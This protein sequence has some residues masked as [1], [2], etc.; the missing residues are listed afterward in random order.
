MSRAGGGKLLVARD[1]VGF[2]VGDGELRL[3]VEHFFKMRDVPACIGRVAV[4]AP[5]KMIVDAPGG[6]V[7]QRGEVHFQRVPAL[8]RIRAVAGVDA[9]EQVE[10]DGLRK[11]RRVAET[12]VLGVEASGE[13]LATGVEQCEAGHGLAG[14]ARG[15]R[16][17]LAQLGDDLV[18][19]LLDFGAMLAPGV[20]DLGQD[21]CQAGLAAAVGGGK[22]GAAGERLEF[23]RQKD[24][25]G[26]AAAAG[27]R[28]DE[29]HVGGVH[30]GTFL[31]VH[32]DR[33]E[34]VVHELGDGRILE[35]FPL[36]HVAPVAGRVADGKEDGLVF[37]ARLGEGFLAPRIPIDG[38][39]RVLEQVGRFL[40]NEAVGVLR[41][42]AD[43]GLGVEGRKGKQNDTDEESR[44]GMEEGKSEHGGKSKPR[45][46]TRRA[47][48]QAG[49]DRA[50][51]G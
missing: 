41:G 49:M 27:R 23:R 20:G 43:G 50:A 25:H 14:L 28:L 48:R 37:L 11:L 12:A 8:G 31:A 7:T 40:V 42:R 47:R 16:R 38:I 32:L 44:R 9:G 22:V 34:G 51:A 13:L 17:E 5:A 21:G 46:V 24:R 29:S 30:V 26:P 39:V 2:Q 45:G 15:G 3:V 4:E 33:H 10:R 6:H 35:G 1:L 19:L 36:H 18:G